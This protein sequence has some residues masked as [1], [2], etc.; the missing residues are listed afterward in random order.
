MFQFRL[1]IIAVSSGGDQNGPPRILF[2]RLGDHYIHVIF[3]RR[4]SLKISVDDFL[5]F[6]LLDGS[7]AL[8]KFQKAEIA[9]R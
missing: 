2:L 9:H 3:D 6:F 1:L 5:G 4:N 7:V 8:R